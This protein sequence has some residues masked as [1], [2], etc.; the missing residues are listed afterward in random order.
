MIFSHRNSNIKLINF[1]IILEFAELQKHNFID[2]N[3]VKSFKMPFFAD[4]LKKVET[5]VDE[6]EYDAIVFHIHAN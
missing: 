4:S 1:S 3:Y 5:E 6:I 2:F